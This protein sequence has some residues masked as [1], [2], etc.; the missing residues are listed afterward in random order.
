[1]ELSRQDN[2]TSWALGY[3]GDT[4]NTAI[5][6][7][8]FGHDVAYF[9]AIGDDP[10][11]HE[12]KAQWRAEGLDASLI[13]HD[14]ERLMG[15]YAIRTDDAGERSFYYWRAMSAARHIFNLPQ[16]AAAIE[17]AQSADML[18]F[19]LISLAILDQAGRRTLFELCQKVRKRGG[20]VVFDGNYRPKLWARRDEAVMARDAAIGVSDIGLPTLSDETMLCG[21]TKAAAVLRQW[22]GPNGAL[23]AVKGYDYATCAMKGHT[24][25][26]WVVM[27]RGAIPERDS[28]APY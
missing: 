16:S 15:L 26:G 14:P 11:S 10:F 27:R 13:L 17:V 23:V 28:D 9:T 24:L 8:R 22:R 18:V 2:A 20:K 25:A 3:G 7:A 5:H 19:S 12:L 21:E 6:M 4:L 1:M